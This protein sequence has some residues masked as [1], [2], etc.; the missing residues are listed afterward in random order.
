MVGLQGRFSGIYN[1]VKQLVDDGVIGDVLS[2]NVVAAAS[3]GGFVE[4]ENYDYF[5]ERKFGGNILTVQVAH[6][7]WGSLFERCETDLS[8]T[9]TTS[10]MP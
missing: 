4:P 9:S 2:T 6:S 3:E 5:Y 1:K 7:K 10:L 8:K